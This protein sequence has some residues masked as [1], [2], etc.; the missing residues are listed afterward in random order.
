[1]Y[2]GGTVIELFK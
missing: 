1:M 2:I